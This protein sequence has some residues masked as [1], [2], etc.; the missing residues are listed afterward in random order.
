MLTSLLAQRGVCIVDRVVQRR[1]Q[2]DEVFLTET[3]R[4]LVVGG[5]DI[6]PSD[7]FSYF[8][9]QFYCAH[10]GCRLMDTEL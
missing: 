1:R 10:T 8:C 9:V 6:L 4:Q 2:L 5:F 7:A 3:S